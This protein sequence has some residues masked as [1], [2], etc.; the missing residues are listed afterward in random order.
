VDW[1]ATK[2]A[3]GSRL[4]TENP[5]ADMSESVQPNKTPVRPIIAHETYKAL[6]RGARKKLPLHMRVFLALTEGTGRRAGAIRA[7]EW[8]D[9]SFPER[10]ILWRAESDK[11]EFQMS[12]AASTRVMRYLKVWR[13]NCPSSKWVFPAPND[14]SK[15]VPKVTVDKWPTSLYNAAGLIKPA[16][17]GWHSFRRKWASERDGYSLAAFKE[18]GGWASSAALMRYLKTDKRQVAAVIQNPTRRV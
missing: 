11:M 15:P 18:A 4:L 9:V 1:P 14:A 10:E 5:I 12:R 16:R 3:N 6:R 2:T 17:A 8:S 7:L 13:H